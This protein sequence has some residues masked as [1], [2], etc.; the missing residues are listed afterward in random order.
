MKYKRVIVKLSGEALAGSHKSGI[1]ETKDVLQISKILIEIA[2]KGIDVGVVIGAGNICRGAILEKVGVDRVTGDKMGMLGTIINSFA[3]ADAIKN[4]GH[5]ASTLSS[6]DMTQFCETFDVSVTDKL[7]K[8]GNIVVF[9]GGTGKPFYST[10]TCAALRAIEIGADA[11][12]MAKNG[13]DGIYD[14]NPLINKDAKMFKEITCSEIIRRELKVIDES[15]ARLLMDKD[16]DVAVFNMANIENFIKVLNGEN[17][18]TI[19][20]KG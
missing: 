20:K 18:G 3:I 6:I 13:V 9:G 8:E 10:D 15:A 19:I 12:L 2:N 11:I 14:D 5:K 16:I 7:F 1:L 4:L 17:V